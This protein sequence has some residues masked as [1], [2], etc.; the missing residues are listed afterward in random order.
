MTAQIKP[1][2]PR[3]AKR[4]RGRRRLAVA[5][6][7][8]LSV[9]VVVVAA[10]AARLATLPAPPLTVRS[11]VSSSTA[12][13]GSL[14]K[15][16]WPAEGAAALATGDGALLGTSGPATP[17]P[18]ASVTKVMTAYLVLRDHPLQLV[19]AG[20]PQGGLTLTVTADEAATLPARIAAGQSVVAVH[21]GS[22]LTEYQALQALLLA[23]ADNIADALAVQDAGS[24]AAFVAKMN[25]TASAMGLKATHY[26]DPSGL[27]PA[28]AST[29]TDQLRLARVA[30]AD[31][32]F[33]AIVAQR[34]ASIPGIGP[35]TNY[36]ALAGTDGFTGVKTGSTGAAGGCLVFSVTRTV[37]GHAY[38]FIGA[39]LGQ[40][41]GPYIAAA[42]AASRVLANSAFANIEERTVLPAGQIVLAVSRADH[43]ETVATGT[44]LRLV[45][46]PGE[47]VALHVA[48][49][50]PK[51]RSAGRN[52]AYQVVGADSG[53]SASVAL[54]VPPLPPPT[55]DWK[56]AH[57]LP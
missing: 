51:S 44:P 11:L 12:L 19:L 47:S 52:P 14:S 35:I 5:A 3:H 23:S 50:N 53:S 57:L 48:P 9:V 22:V 36:N 8:V 2:A 34:S 42:L 33:A 25:A 26:A 10:A 28:S 1:A 39:V 46:L 29:P 7:V 30:L 4:P 13:P 6:I 31:P 56:L 27:D 16:A 18:I 40:Q 43:H 21:A 45:G 24:T 20:P 17:A 32:V 37:A 49:T 54:V 41:R 38:T 55:F 15:L